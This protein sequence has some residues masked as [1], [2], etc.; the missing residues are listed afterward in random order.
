MPGTTPFGLVHTVSSLVAIAAGQIALIRAHHNAETTIRVPAGA[1]WAPIPD[2]PLALGLTAF[3]FGM[4]VLMALL[5]F[6]STGK[7]D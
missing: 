5:Q 3:A 1:P 7:N 2:A 4:F 6:L